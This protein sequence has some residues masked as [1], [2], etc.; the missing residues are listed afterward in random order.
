MCVC[1]RITRTH[2]EE[3]TQRITCFIDN[4]RDFSILVCGNLGFIWLLVENGEYIG[5]KCAALWNNESKLQVLGRWPRGYSTCAYMRTRVWIIITSYKIA[6]V[7]QPAC[8]PGVWETEMGFPWKAS[9]LEYPNW[10]V[11]VSVRDFVSVN[12][13]GSDPGRQLT[14]IHYTYTQRYSQTHILAHTWKRVHI[15]ILKK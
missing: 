13:V 10:Q 4:S 2:T 14:P 1:V 12:K 7:Q 6:T 9:L 3:Y 15:N 5:S 8:N 11:S